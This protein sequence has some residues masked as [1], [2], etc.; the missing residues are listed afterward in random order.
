VCP[1]GYTWR[2]EHLWWELGEMAGTAMFEVKMRGSSA[3]V[4]LMDADNYQAYCDNEAYTFYGDFTD[5][6]PSYVQVPYDG[7]WYL[8]VD[9]YP[10]RIKVWVSQYFHDD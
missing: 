2:V 5:T 10:G 7:Y 8:V 4:A 9:S 1:V 3:R 6:T